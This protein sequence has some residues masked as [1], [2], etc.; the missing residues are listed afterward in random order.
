MKF[1]FALFPHWS[2]AWPHY[3]IVNS[4]QPVGPL[5]T[6]YILIWHSEKSIALTVLLTAVNLRWEN[7]VSTAHFFLLIFFHKILGGVKN[8]YEFKVAESDQA[9]IC[10]IMLRFLKIQFVNNLINIEPILIQS[11]TLEIHYFSNN[12]SHPKPKNHYAYI[13]SKLLD[14]LP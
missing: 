11:F 13:W 4:Q 7:R 9:F 10:L 3:A 12:F 1:Q 6:F 5:C 8:C 14:V 2:H